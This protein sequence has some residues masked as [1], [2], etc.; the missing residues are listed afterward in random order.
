[1]LDALITTRCGLG[2]S[3]I[4]KVCN[5]AVHLQVMTR[6][7]IDMLVLVLPKAI[8]RLPSVLN[9]F[10]HACDCAYAVA[11]L[12]E[13]DAV[14]RHQDGSPSVLDTLDLQLVATR[15]LLIELNT[16]SVVTHCLRVVLA[17]VDV[18]MSKQREL[19]AHLDGKDVAQTAHDLVR[20]SF[21]LVCT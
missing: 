21:V 2:T 17:G 8:A 6:M 16:L 5:M 11:E 7:W 1:M 10:A 13:Q 12:R 4:N 18:P 19:I 3:T 9:L 20:H 14:K 15:Q